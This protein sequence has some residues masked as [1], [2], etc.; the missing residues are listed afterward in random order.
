MV[1]WTV[2]HSGPKAESR[3]QLV[4]DKDNILINAYESFIAKVNKSF[5]KQFIYLILKY[6]HADNFKRS[7]NILFIIPH[8]PTL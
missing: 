7:L 3:E 4:T 1:Y 5:W 8:H 6:D 2:A